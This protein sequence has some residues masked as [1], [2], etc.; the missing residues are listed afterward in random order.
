[1]T[2]TSQDRLEPQEGDEA[3]LD[4]DNFH[5]PRTGEWWEHETVW[6]WWFAPERALGC[7]VYHYVRPNIGVAGGGVLVFDASAWFYMETPYYYSYSNT[8][9]K[10]DRDLRDFT[11][12]GGSRIE[13]LEPLER[14]RLSFEDSDVLRYDVNWEAV[15]KP[16]ANLSRQPYGGGVVDDEPLARHLDQFGHVTGTVE[17]HGERI[18]IDCY[19][20][21]DRS[22]WHLRPESWKE[23]GGGGNYITAMADPTTAFFRDG[24]GGFL[25]L[26]GVRSPLVSGTRKRERDPEHGFMRKIIVTGVDGE[27]RSFEAIGESVSRVAIP[28]VGVHG[29][30]WQSLVRY[31]I[32]G[33]PAWGDDQDAWPITLWSAFRRGQMGLTDG[34]AARLPEDL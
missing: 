18:P 15:M 2:D 12:P 27:G 10:D 9:L 22:W 1:M 17:L 20:M 30:C 32:N 23:G 24:P 34:R 3:L 5:T 19:A 29:V 7:W 25:L 16:S 28:I 14:Y 33:I 26:D 31:T 13:M 8:R 6:F 21:R 4:D 11:F